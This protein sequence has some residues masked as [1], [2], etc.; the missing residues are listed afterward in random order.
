MRI[1]VLI[2]VC[3]RNQHWTRLEDSFLFQAALPS[4]AR[5]QSQG[6]TY[7][8]YIGMDDDDH[9]FLDARDRIPGIHVLLKGCQHAPATAW[10]QLFERAIQD[11]HEYY[12]QMADDVVIETPG[13]TERFVAALQE[14]GNR[15]VVGPCHLENYHGRLARGQQYCIENA[16]VHKTHWDR[17]GFFYPPEIKNWYCD[18]W[19]T[20]VYSGTLSLMMEDI[21]VRNLSIRTAQQRYDVSVPRWKELID[22]HRWR[23]VHGCFSFCLFGEFTTKYYTGLV[24]NV[25]LIRQHFPLWDIHVYAAP[26]AVEFVRFLSGVRCIPTGASGAVNMTYRFL[27]TIDP[28]YDAVCV[29][30]TD[31]R[32]HARDRWCI[33]HFLGSPYSMYT[34]RDHPW[35]R[36]RVMGGLWGVKRGPHFSREK[37]YNYCHTVSAGYTSDTQFLDTHLESDRRIVYSYDPHGLFHDPTETVVPI[38]CPGDFCG[39]VV[40]FDENGAEYCEFALTHT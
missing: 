1:A 10:N 36:Y 33:R 6:Y 13:W 8:Y 40:L 24:R 29:R 5:T 18:D 31:S 7:T 30:D 20:Q 27:S 26:E 34:I 32:I 39:N 21:L 9:F 11:K 35:H 15:G 4:L 25:E 28:V 14:N 16:F 23:T 2:P 38:A 3:S 19:I 17:F 22:E 12:F 37:L